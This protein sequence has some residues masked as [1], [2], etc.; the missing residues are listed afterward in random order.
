[1]EKPQRVQLKREK[2][3][4]M[5]AGT[6]KVDRTTKFGNPFTAYGPEKSV[7]FFRLWVT[8]E[9][10]DEDIGEKFPQIVAHHLISRRKIIQNALPELAGKNLSC[11]CGG[12]GPCHA[13]VL[14]ELA[15]NLGPLR[16]S[17]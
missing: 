7:Q 5:P 2:G 16:K 9:L 6:V 13:D 10:T 12:E 11:W 8:G 17:A 1:M 4:R 3:W 14:I 15:A